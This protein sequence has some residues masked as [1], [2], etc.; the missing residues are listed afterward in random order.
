MG[1]YELIFFISIVIA[2]VVFAAITMIIILSHPRS[3]HGCRNNDK[4]KKAH[5]WRKEFGCKEYEGR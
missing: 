3:C 4:C 5:G 2:T 1:L